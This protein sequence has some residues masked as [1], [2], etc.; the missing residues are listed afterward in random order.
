[1]TIT[2]IAPDA[3]RP[4]D[5]PGPTEKPA[6]KPPVPPRIRWRVVVRTGATGKMDPSRPS[7]PLAWHLASCTASED[8][9]VHCPEG[10]R[11]LAAGDDPDGHCLVDGI[12]PRCEMQK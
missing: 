1:M 7:R 6:L 3:E 5:K 11:L 2:S 10:R 9:D 4:A 8:P 12:C